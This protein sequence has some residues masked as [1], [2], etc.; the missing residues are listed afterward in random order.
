LKRLKVDENLPESV[1]ER[2]RGAG[3]DARSVLEQGLAG[4]E[5]QAID[6]VLR[7]E[8]R[9]LVTLDL[10]FADI[11]RHPPEHY[12]GLIVLRLVRQ[13]LSQLLEVIE[14]L[15]PFLATN[16]LAGRLLDRPPRRT[17][18]QGLRRCGCLLARGAGR[19]F[20]ITRLRWQPRCALRRRAAGW[21]P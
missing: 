13:D 20:A 7:R 1:A 11:R 17:P 18:D 5:D 8:R 16:P 2:L 9:A 21:S 14:R 4:S 6:T 3:H 10:G 15:I 12:H 19:S